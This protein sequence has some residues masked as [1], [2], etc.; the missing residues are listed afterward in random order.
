MFLCEPCFQNRM[1]DAGMKD[2]G[3]MSSFF[4]GVS[5]GACE[6]CHE[7]AL[8]ADPP[9]SWLPIPSK[10]FRYRTPRLESQDLG[11]GFRLV[12]QAHQ[13]TGGGMVRAVVK[14]AQG[15]ITARGL[16]VPKADADV[17]K[18]MALMEHMAARMAP[19]PPAFTDDPMDDDEE[20]GDPRED[21]EE[22]FS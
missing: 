22:D 3:K 15:N 10:N 20:D 17:S 4:S 8:C 21:M 14:N 18:R 9:S 6:D 7:S 19:P 2:A 12:F 5:R 16:T 11:G 1:K 13:S